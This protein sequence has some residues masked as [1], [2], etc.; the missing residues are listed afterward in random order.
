MATYTLTIEEAPTNEDVEAL[1]QGL[2]VHALP[3][4][5]VPG[6]QPLHDYPHGYQRFFM[7]KTLS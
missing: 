3:Y 7:K 2:T 5:K 1:G 4:T 6:F